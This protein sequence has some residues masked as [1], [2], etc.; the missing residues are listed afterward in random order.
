MSYF[1]IGYES[2]RFSQT[3]DGTTQTFEY[4]IC[5]PD[6]ISDQVAWDTLY[7]DFFTPNDDVNILKYI[8]DN[9][10]DSR[11]FP[12]SLGDVELF[13]N[14]IS[15]VEQVDG[16][17]KVTLTYSLPEKE[18]NSTHIQFGFSTNGETVHISQAISQRSIVAQSGSSLIPPETYRGI[19]KNGT[20]V[21]GMD[22]TDPGLSFNITGY[23]D[24][25]IWTTSVM[26]TYAS[27]SKTYNNAT[28]YG[29]PA[30]SVL[31]DY[32][33]AN[34]EA[35][36]YVPVTFNFIYRPNISGVADPPFPSLTK[37]GHDIVDYIYDPRISN[38]VQLLHPVFRQILQ[39][40]EPGNFDLL[41]I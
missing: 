41:G 27:L 23:F 28:F 15:G 22:I 17:W 11:V 38:S 35:F 5:E 30:G 3:R 26:L 18:Q 31:F 36:K 32:C 39:V 10:P 25:S 1:E 4:Y 40:R 16:G 37:L 2:R 19:G 8:Y 33:D 21:D 24:P 13:I 6:A 34:S 14:D 7:G 29:F 9:F 20:N 12:T